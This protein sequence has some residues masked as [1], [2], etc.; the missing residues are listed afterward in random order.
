[1]PNMNQM[2]SLFDGF[3][4]PDMA[5]ATTN[6]PA[7]SSSLSD[8]NTVITDVAK[9]IDQLNMRMERL[10]MAVEDGADKNVKAVR[11]KGNILA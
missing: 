7:P 6:T 5:S 9:G 3:K 11:S 10:I 1:M 4:M 8:Q 2:T